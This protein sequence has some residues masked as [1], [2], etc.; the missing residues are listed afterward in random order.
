MQGAEPSSPRVRQISVPASRPAA[1]TIAALT[2]A[3]CGS[4]CS[5]P[6]TGY[7]GAPPTVVCGTTLDRSAAGAV[8]DNATRPWP[9]VSFPTVGGVLYIRVARGCAHG[10]HVHWTPPGAARLVR[11][12]RAADGLPV[13]VILKPRTPHSVFRVTATRDGQTVASI[14]VHL[15]S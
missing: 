1:A 9:T 4:A 7:S 6:V 11:A 8:I 12:A 5:P 15:R 3:A 13:V 2:I 10:A 14:K